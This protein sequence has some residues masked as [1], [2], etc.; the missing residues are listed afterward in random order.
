MLICLFSQYSAANMD[1]K[2][3]TKTKLYAKNDH[4]FYN[5]TQCKGELTGQPIIFE[6]LLN[7]ISV[8][9]DT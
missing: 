6:W 9:F 4:T 3:L 2:F 5:V 1:I 8:I 7:L